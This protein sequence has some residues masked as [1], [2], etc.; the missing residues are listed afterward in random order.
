DKNADY[1]DHIAITSGIYP[2]EKTHIEIVRYNKGS[3]AMGSLLTLLTRGGGQIPRAARF[4][5]NIVRHPWEFLKSF[6]IFGWAARTSILL[7]MQTEEN[8]LRLSYKPRWWR[9]GK[10]SMNTELVPGIEKVPSYI[11]IANKV[12]EEMGKKIDGQPMSAVTEV[13]FDISST[14][15]I[16]GGCVMGETA[17]DGVVDF[18][19]KIHGYPNLYVADGSNVPTNLGVN[20]SLTITAIAEYIMSQITENPQNVSD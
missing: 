20:P 15:H 19:G 16:L 9:F 14:A 1:S 11:P 17:D 4:L 10:P 7:V 6:W 2:D 8:F 13:L 12:A 18:N 5:G 3:D